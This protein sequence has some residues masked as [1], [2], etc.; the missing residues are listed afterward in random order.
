ML[1]TL[2]DNGDN[3]DMY[4]V[5]IDVYEECMHTAK[6]IAHKIMLP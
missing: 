6:Y 2:R 5:Y 4:E 3:G 1:Q